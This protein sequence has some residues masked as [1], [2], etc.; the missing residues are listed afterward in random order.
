VGKIARK[1]KERLFKRTFTRSE[2]FFWSIGL[3]VTLESSLCAFSRYWL[4]S[5]LPWLSANRKNSKELWRTEAKV[6]RFTSI[7]FRSSLPTQDPAMQSLVLISKRRVVRKNC[8]KERLLKRNI[9]P[10][11]LSYCH[12][13]KTKQQQQQQTEATAVS[14]HRIPSL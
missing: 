12:C 9:H 1:K 8:K 3:S 5:N 13:I 6:T 14:N 7:P 11:L 2:E 10:R 4:F